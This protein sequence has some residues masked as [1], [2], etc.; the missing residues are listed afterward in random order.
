MVVVVVMA[1]MITTVFP[2]PLIKMCFLN[3]LLNPSQLTN[4][5]SNRKSHLLKDNSY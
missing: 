2:V 4:D 5:N 1:A 3:D